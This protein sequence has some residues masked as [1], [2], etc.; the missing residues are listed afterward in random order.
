VYV[1]D[2][3]IAPLQKFYSEYHPD[4]YNNL[5]LLST[6]GSAC[7]EIIPLLEQRR[8]WMIVRHVLVHHYAHRGIVDEKH[9][10]KQL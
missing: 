4:W 9:Y 8:A 6:E 2:V 1:G 3:K 10:N 5:H 7:D